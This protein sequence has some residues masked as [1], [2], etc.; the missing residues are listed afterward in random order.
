MSH[1]VHP[2]GI[3][4]ST[5]IGEGTRVWA[6]A[7]VLPGARIGRDG[8]ICDHV[9]IENDVVVGDRVT[10]KSGVQLWDGIRL[11]DDVFVGPNV[12]FTND[13]FPR[14]R[15][16][17]TE[18]PQTVVAQGASLGG[19]SVIL[20]GIRIGRRAMVGAGAVVTKDVPA[21]AIVVGNP[22]RI[23]GYTDQE[24]TATTVPHGVEAPAAAP[25]LIRLNRVDDLRG[26]LVSA[27]LTRDLPFVPARFFVVFDVPTK[28]VRGEHAHRRCEQL[29]VALAG[30]V[31]CVVD[32]GRT[33]HSVRLDRPDVAL[34]MPAMT[35]GTQYQYSPD[36]VLGVFAS[37]PYDADD[38]IR[39]YDEFLREV[40][41][42]EQ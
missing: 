22:A 33:R 29:L 41:E 31:T 10:V 18:F 24:A 20:P 39:D 7:H 40:G 35:W 3:C 21:N 19:G 27:E 37:L 6:F 36:A 42:P 34:H 15:V 9:F 2:Q 11:E 28:D 4:E 17:P 5:D 16:W 38:Y 12:T 32:D 23:V 26:G 25:D 13:R 30:S 8:N 1:F 14:S